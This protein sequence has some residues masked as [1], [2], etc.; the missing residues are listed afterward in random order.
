MSHLWVLS[1]AS[2]TG[3]TSLVK[4]LL[5]QDKH[6]QVAVSHTTRKP[7]EGEINGVDYNFVTK[8][9]FEALIQH[10]QFVEY[11]EVFGNYY[12]TSKAEVEK[13]IQSGFDVILEID[14]QGARQIQEQDPAAKSIF[15]FPPSY[16]QLRDRL[17]SRGKDD[18][19]VIERRLSEAKLEISKS[20]YFDYWLIN[21]NFEEALAAL[22]SIIN[23]HRYER[24][25]MEQK[26]PDLVRGICG[27]KD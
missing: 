11:A 17:E 23:A 5:A 20:E 12:G 21:D 26:H 22:N 14:W 9:E 19:A 15:I 18:Q 3:K 25:I 7:R 16:E 13:R 2:G 24:V 8:E 27:A 6:V 1:A 10:E 4:A